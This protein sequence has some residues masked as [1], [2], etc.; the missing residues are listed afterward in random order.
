MQLA[1]SGSRTQRAEERQREIEKGP[2]G[3]ANGTG[4]GTILLEL[5]KDSATDSA[6]KK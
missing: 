1:G 3:K 2:V 4:A 5:A 6:I